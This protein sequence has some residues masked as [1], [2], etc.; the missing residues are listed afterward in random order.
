MK[1]KT[2]IGLVLAICIIGRGMAQDTA[3]PVGETNT[4]IPK[5]LDVHQLGAKGDGKTID[6]EAI[7]KALDEC[8][9]S[10]GGIVRLTSGIYLS[11]PL[12]LRSNTTL[13]LDPDATLKAT[14]DPADFANPKKTGDVIA[15]ING[16]DLKTIAILG[17]GT[18]DGSGARWWEPARAA[19]AGQADRDTTAAANDTLV[20]LYRRAN[21]GC[22]AD[23]FAQFSPGPQGL[24]ECGYRESDLSRAG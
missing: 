1:C 16:S 19:K 20:R 22:D 15:F 10:G 12:F 18:I 17:K 23:Q 5:V 14:D 21:P 9:K 8:G 13:Q 24:R 7:Q 6:T 11:K 4:T 3:K 2:M